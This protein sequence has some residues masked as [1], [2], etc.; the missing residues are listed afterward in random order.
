MKPFSLQVYRLHPQGIRIVPA[1]KTLM[2][3]ANQDALKWCGPFTNANRFGFW[4]FPPMDID[5]IW[6]GSNIFEHNVINE[7]NN[8]EVPFIRS[9]VKDN[10][11]EEEKAFPQQFSGRVKVD[12][13]RVEENICQMW[14]GVSFQTPPE[15][16]LHI[17]SP[18]NI[19]MDAPFRIQEG[20]LETSWLRYDIW[21]NIAVQR[22]DTLIQLRR[23]QWPPLAQL[24]PVRLE[25]YD[26]QWTI[27]EEMFNRDSKE[28]DEA[29]LQWVDYNHKKYLKMRHEKEKDSGTYFKERASHKT[30]C[31]FR[32]PTNI[33]KRFIA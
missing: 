33:P 4:V 6:R 20:I 29:Y 13:G 5:I 32:K 24:L 27:S 31:P 9:L 21:I 2:G 26:Q 11:K 15:W 8:D 22:K 18:I 28:A 1:E 12:F 30:Q 23:D 19:G 14:T 17:R 25:S 7:W 3:T 10:D 16:A